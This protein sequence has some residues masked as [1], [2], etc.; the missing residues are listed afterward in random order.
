MMR[1]NRSRAVPFVA[2]MMLAGVAGASLPIR[3]P[4]RQS[5]VPARFDALGDP[6]PFGAVARLGTARFRHGSEIHHLV[7]TPDGRSIVSQAPGEAGVFVWNAVTGEL[8]QRIGSAPCWCM[9]LSPDGRQLAAGEPGGLIRIWDFATG[10]ELATL[11]ADVTTERMPLPGRLHEDYNIVSRLAFAGGDNRLVSYHTLDQS[12]R[13]W[14]L[15][16]RQPI[17]QLPT[18]DEAA[19]VSFVASNDGRRLLA[20]SARG[21]LSVWSLPDATLL[22]RFAA[23]SE[24][25]AAMTMT[26][27]GSTAITS[28]LDAQ[29]RGWD[30][31]NGRER[32][33]H[34]VA[35]VVG[36]IALAPDAKSFAI[37]EHVTDSDQSCVQLRSTETGRVMR[38]LPAPMRS[39]I[40]V[41]WDPT[42]S[43]L[44]TGG[45]GNSIRLW[46]VETGREIR[47][48]IGHHGPITTV[49]FA[50]D[51]S[52]VATCS[53]HDPTVRVWD[54]RTGRG[55]RLLEDH[56]AGVDEVQ[57][58][59]DG[60]WIA[61][62]CWGQ[63]VLL[64]DAA[65]G[66]L[67]HALADHPSVGPH[68]RFS[69][70][71][72]RIATAGR[73]GSVGVWDCATGRRIAEYSAPPLDVAAILAFSDGRLLA[74]ERPDPEGDADGGAISV[75]DV[76][77]G[78]VVRRF[79]GHRAM[80]NGVVLS[81]DLR[82]LASRGE[83]QTIRIWEM[84]TGR[85]RR[86]F[87][88]PGESSGWTGTQFLSFSPNGRMLASGGTQEPWARL[89]DL[90]A[91]RERDPVRGHRGWIG[92][93]EF[94]PD[95]RRL[96]TGSQDTTVLLWDVARP[97]A[98]QQPLS[99]DALARCWDALAGDDAQAAY[100]AIWRLID[101]GDA[102]TAFLAGKLRPTS[103]ADRQQIVRWI[104][105]LDHPQFAVRERASAALARI[106]DQAE[107]EL[108]RAL[109]QATPETQ[110]RIRRILDGMIDTAVTPERLRLLRAAEVLEGQ[111]TPAARSL[112][113][114]LAGGDP[115]SQLT[116]D[117]RESLERLNR[118]SGGP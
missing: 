81:G 15:S 79:V 66:R 97:P 106:A 11:V 14:D 94:S 13:I 28:G 84:A 38:T 74:L 19:M 22:R 44:A 90:A 91:G 87:R 55:V 67:R 102:A 89:W 52:R 109:R 88:D 47:P 54:A 10:T 32:W 73:G 62:G 111:G 35:G 45:G 29:L 3:E 61:T 100:S 69:P 9:A 30:L 112:L 23:H 59:P 98:S 95:G 116:R 2:L 31:A 51:G 86:V 37:T 70:D 25:I 6:L 80:V 50:P 46:N 75:W 85:E 114:G 39:A 57:F 115:H 60:R 103:G 93:L 26:G 34:T 48:T 17:A 27:D 56:P 64:W 113:T 43:V 42:G 101:A 82:T 4:E 117:A 65:D 53:A 71:G 104:E 68:F 16:R 72:M 49:S 96:A 77:A 12:I 36:Q 118:R 8:R 5:R 20:A 99:P 107:D 76:I 108:R 24:P 21:D 63:P 105:Q 41:A 78:R 7:V 110:L 58:S 40:G 1:T 83:D 33:R 18:D 92:A